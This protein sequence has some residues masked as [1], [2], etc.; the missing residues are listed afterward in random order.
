VLLIVLAL[1]TGFG[2]VAPPARPCQAPEYRQFDFW[3]GDWV[4]HDANGQR[5]G[6]NHIESIENGCGIQ[7]SWTDRS[8][9]TG[10]SITAFRPTSK[11]W[12]QLWTSSWGGILLLEGR[13]DDDRM[14]LT[15][16]AVGRDGSIERQR[17]TWS[18]TENGVRQLAERSR[19]GGRT[20]TVAFD[21]RYVRA[22][23]QP[24]AE[25]GTGPIILPRIGRK[26]WDLVHFPG[27]RPPGTQIL[28][29]QTFEKSARTSNAMCRG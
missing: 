1:I 14:V 16:D 6:A 23:K 7:E 12:T 21:G 28:R 15:G 11:T 18:H 4:V 20:W 3:I 27:A 10:R 2:Q 5:I 29:R 24:A 26:K 8:G 17:T 9:L 13:Y 25:K 19:D 22:A